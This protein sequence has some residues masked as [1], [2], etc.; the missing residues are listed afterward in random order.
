MITLSQRWKDRYPGASVGILAMHGVLNSSSHLAL[1]AQK[2][3]LEAE[4]RNRFADCDRNDLKDTEPISA[5]NAYLKTFKKTYHVQLQL[6]SVLFKGKPIPRAAALV[7]AMFMAELQDLLLTAGHDMDVL[8]L[9]LNIDISK[10]SER[11][12][13]LRGEE[14]VLKP[15]DMIISDRAGII[16]SVVYGPDCRTQIKPETQNVLF[17][18]Y[19]PPGIMYE[20]VYEHLKHIQANVLLIAGEA[21]VELLYVYGTT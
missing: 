3:E 7:E 16:S 8:Q 20:S 18:T 12:I 5:Y 19:A 13:G 1:D 15:G 10:G 14:Q 21:E 6:E 9:P 11:Y 4:L 17:A 2:A